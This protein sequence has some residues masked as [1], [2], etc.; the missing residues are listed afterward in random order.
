MKSKGLFI[1]RD[2][3]VAT[4]A[5]WSCHKIKF[6]CVSF[7]GPKTGVQDADGGESSLQLQQDAEPTE[8]RHVD[9]DESTTLG[10]HVGVGVERRRR[11]RGV[12]SVG[13]Q[14]VGRQLRQP[15]GREFRFVLVRRISLPPR[16]LILLPSFLLSFLLYFHFSFLPSF[17]RLPI[18]P[19]ALFHGAVHSFQILAA[20]S[21]CQRDS[22]QIYWFFSCARLPDVLKFRMNHPELKET[23][24][25]RNVS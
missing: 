20:F 4:P 7:W 21:E 17:S 25:I 13:A 23:F 9:G 6:F 15:P 22:F 16:P 19:D 14:S 12:D 8:A 5:K 11:R 10:V 24:F 1:G 2:V 3:N 18:A